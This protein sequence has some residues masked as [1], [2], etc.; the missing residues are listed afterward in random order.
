M[1]CEKA[2]VSNDLADFAFR[3]REGLYAS[4]DGVAQKDR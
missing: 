2:S 3:E 1:L 4:D